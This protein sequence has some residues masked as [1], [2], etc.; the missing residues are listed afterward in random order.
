M[1]KPEP[2]VEMLAEFFSSWCSPFAMG[3]LQLVFLYFK[4]LF[5]VLFLLPYV[6]LYIGVAL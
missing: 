5:Y 2:G 1:G 4:F 6:N 3:Q